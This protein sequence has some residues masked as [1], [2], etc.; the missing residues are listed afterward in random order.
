MMV[1]QFLTV[2]SCGFRPVLLVFD[3]EI[4]VEY[5]EGRKVGVFLLRFEKLMSMGVIGV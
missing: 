3:L 4:Q 1:L 2:P 5:R